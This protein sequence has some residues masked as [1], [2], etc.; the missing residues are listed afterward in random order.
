[1]VGLK[2]SC[3]FTFDSW[4]LTFYLYLLTQLEFGDP[5]TGLRWGINL[6]S[7]LYKSPGEKTRDMVRHRTG[8]QTDDWRHQPAVTCCSST[9]TS[10]PRAMQRTA[11][12][13]G[14]FCEIYCAD[15][16]VLH[17]YTSKLFY[18]K[19]MEDHYL[20][21]NKVCFQMWFVSIAYVCEHKYNILP[22]Y[23]IIMLFRPM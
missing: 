22:R 15:N 17:F 1:M 20:F 18:S 21:Y 9:C 2:I 12:G 6:H 16:L 5:H 23:I 4:W 11:S 7:C 10:C 19:L 13:G 3:L 8:P 14:E